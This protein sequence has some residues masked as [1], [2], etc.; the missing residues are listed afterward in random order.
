MR[1]RRKIIGY[2]KGTRK[3]PLP[4]VLRNGQC[5]AEERRLLTIYNSVFGVGEAAVAV[6]VDRDAE[7]AASGLH[8][9]ALIVRTSNRRLP[10]FLR[11]T[12]KAAKQDV[13]HDGRT[14]LFIADVIRNGVLAR[15]RF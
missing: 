6:D 8:D 3:R 13:C 4:L 7:R 1:W 12:R 14:I 10:E 15:R 5:L 2:K 9:C 11:K